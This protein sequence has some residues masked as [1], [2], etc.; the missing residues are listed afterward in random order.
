VWLADLEGV[1]AGCAHGPKATP[2]WS[3]GARESCRDRAIPIGRDRIVVPLTDP[4]KVTERQTQDLR[5]EKKSGFKRSPLD[6]NKWTRR[7]H[8]GCLGLPCSNPSPPPISPPLTPPGVPRG[9]TCAARC[10]TRVYTHVGT[11]TPP[12]L[13]LAVPSPSHCGLGVA[14]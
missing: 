14:E 11:R 8:R 12:F 6:R 9:H 3:F 4:P 7:P 5:T 1:G 10:W 13:A 2:N